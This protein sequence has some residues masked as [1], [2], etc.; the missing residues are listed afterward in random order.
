MDIFDFPDSGDELK[1]IE[2]NIKNIKSSSS[3]F[4]SDS[5]KKIPKNSIDS[6][7]IDQKSFSSVNVVNSSTRISRFL[8][9]KTSKSASSTNN[10]HLDNCK[11]GSSSNRKS[12]DVDDVFDFVNL[13]KGKQNEAY[14]V[15][16]RV[17]VMS[18][19]PVLLMIKRITC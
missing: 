17:G 2:K 9:T 4:T 16:Q 15:N 6:S 10:H 14:E 11:N 7:Y 3:F 1:K 5:P 18:Q 13:S 12:V 19:S 8:T